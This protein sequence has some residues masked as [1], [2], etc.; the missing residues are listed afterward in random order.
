MLKFSKGSKAGDANDLCNKNRI[1][2]IVCEFIYSSPNSFSTSLFE[3]LFMNSNLFETLLGLSAIERTSWATPARGPDPPGGLYTKIVRDQI[4]FASCM[5]SSRQHSR[6]SAF[7]ALRSH[8]QTHRSRGLGSQGREGENN[9]MRR[10]TE[11][12]KTIMHFLNLILPSPCAATCL[13]SCDASQRIRR[14]G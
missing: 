3:S 14:S 10:V 12:E 7:R 9:A 1:D 6:P 13:N 4:Y 11:A 5:L 2:R 8:S